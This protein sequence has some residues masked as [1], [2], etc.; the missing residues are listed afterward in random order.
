MQRFLAVLGHL[1]ASAV[2]LKAYFRMSR[3]VVTTPI[4]TTALPSS[5]A[6]G[7][8]K[9]TSTSATFANSAHLPRTDVKHIAQSLNYVGRNMSLALN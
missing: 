3:G 4:E 5:P 2:G 6:R 1:W 7:Y 9:T 8:F